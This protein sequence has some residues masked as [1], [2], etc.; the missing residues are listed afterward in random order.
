M[1][2]PLAVD[3]AGPRGH[4]AADAIVGDLRLRKQLLGAWYDVPNNTFARARERA[5]EDG[6]RPL[7]SE[8]EPW[9]L[10]D[11]LVGSRSED[12]ALLLTANECVSYLLRSARDLLGRGEHIA[13]VCPDNSI[14]WFLPEVMVLAK[15]SR[16]HS[17]VFDLC[18]FGGKRKKIARMVTT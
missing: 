17:V 16:V 2:L 13:L 11:V 15:D 8:S 3:L 12:A 4:R 10:V 18:R 1:T 14:F 7:R 9:G 6:P 5:M